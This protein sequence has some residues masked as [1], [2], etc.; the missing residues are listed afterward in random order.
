MQ[1]YGCPLFG[2]MSKNLEWS[3]EWS[4]SLTES[5]LSAHKSLTLPWLDGGV[6]TDDLRSRIAHLHR[7]AGFGARPDELDAAVAAVTAATVDRLLD[8]NGP[9]AGADAASG[10]PP[11]LTAPAAVTGAVDQ[12]IVR[13]EA[14]ALG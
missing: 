13:D 6:A 3:R 11:P 14:N 5:P 8:L 9:D 4:R 10:P 1:R 2:R 7:R 12:K